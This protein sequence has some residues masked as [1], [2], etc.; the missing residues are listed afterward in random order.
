MSSWIRSGGVVIAGLVI[1]DTGWTWLDPVVSPT[2]VAIIVWGSWG[3]LRDSLAR[4]SPPFRRASTQTRSE[5]A[6]KAWWV[7][8][9][10]MT[11]LSGQ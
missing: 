4:P 9:P 3:P 5:A 8:P 11:C 6:S 7:S 1:L 10:S 2:I